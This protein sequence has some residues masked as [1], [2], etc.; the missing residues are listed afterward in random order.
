MIGILAF[1]KSDDR[2]MIDVTTMRVLKNP[3]VDARARAVSGGLKCLAPFSAA[4]LYIKPSDIVDC[5]P[6][7]LAM[8]LAVFALHKPG[9]LPSSLP[10]PVPQQ[11]AFPD[12]ASNDEDV[13]G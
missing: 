1:L 6:H 4:S 8:I 11:Q 9:V 7:G 10:K 13:D 5:V 12:D 2:N 3:D